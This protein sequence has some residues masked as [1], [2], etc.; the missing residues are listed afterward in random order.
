[1]NAEVM[2]SQ[3][4][5]QIGPLTGMEAADQLWMARYI[6]LRVAEEHDVHV[7]F[8][9]KVVAGFSGSGC[10]CNASMRRTR[11]RDS[12][13][14]MEGVMK[15]VQ[16]LER[17]HVRLM[18][19]DTYGFGNAL[20]LTGDFETAPITAFSYGVGDR[21]ASIRIPFDFSGYIEDRRPAANADPYEVTAYMYARFLD[22]VE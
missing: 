13:D 7:S 21:G 19:A 6:L 20:R 16:A 4:E 17:D 18:A 10:H 22:T 15:W 1:M 12:Q 5:F 9:P 8:N 2:Q 14:D 11:E 3:W